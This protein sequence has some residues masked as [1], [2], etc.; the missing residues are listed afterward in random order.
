MAKTNGKGFF[1]AKNLVLLALLSAILV[2]MAF[3]PLGYLNVGVLAITFNVIPVA[4]GAVTLGWK[5]GAILGGV[6]GLTSFSQCFGGSVLGTLLFGISPFKTFIQCMIPRI[7]MGVCIGLI[8]ALSVKLIK[9]KSVCFAITGLFS[10]LLNT[11][12]Y[13]SSLIILF[14]DT[15]F[16]QDK[17]EAIAKGKNVIVFIAAFV[18][19]NALVEA[20][21]ATI[22]TAAICTA[23]YHSRF[24]KIKSKD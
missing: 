18:G 11:A 6:F 7:L 21:S 5:G 8:F 3:T 17:W 12:F 4:I 19:V 24:F 13:M 22:I 15:D 9:S 10:A 14:G 20:L 2:V 23:L 1:N 16:I